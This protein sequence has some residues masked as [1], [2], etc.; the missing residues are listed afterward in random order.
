MADRLLKRYKAASRP[1]VVAEA[2]PGGPPARQGQLDALAAVQKRDLGTYVR[3]YAFLGQM[4]D[5]GNTAIEKRAI[6]FKRLLPLLEF[7]RRREGIDLSKVVLTHHR[8][9]DQGS[10]V[11]RWASRGDYR[12]QPMTEPGGGQVQDKEGAAVGDRRQGQ[13]PVRGEL[14]DDDKLVY[15]NHVLKGKLLESDLLRQQGGQ[16]RK[17]QFANSPDLAHEI[18]N[19]V[20]DALA[21]HTTMNK[22]ALDSDRV[23]SGLEHPA[24]A[25]AAV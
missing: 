22:Q 5:Y 24:R 6:F 17:E 10:G 1:A 13:R 20:M 18:L 12:L 15:V 4:F 14:T 3:V 7:G 2:N 9:K 11:W 23:R 16:Q 25:G 8:L 21:A 19:A